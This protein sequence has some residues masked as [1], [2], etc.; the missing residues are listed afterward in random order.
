MRGVRI[1]VFGA[2]GHN[3]GDEAVAVAT[4]EE[5]SRRFP[6]AEFTLASRRPEMTARATGVAT[7]MGG[8]RGLVSAWREIR[9]STHLLI[10][11]GTLIQDELYRGTPWRGTMPSAVIAAE[12]ARRKGIPSASI[13]IG[14]ERLRMRLSRVLARRLA[15]NLDPLIVRDVTSAEELR[16]IGVSPASLHV[17]ADPAVLLAEEEPNG[18]VAG[19]LRGP[20]VAVSVLRENLRPATYRRAVVEACRAALAAGRRIVFIPMDDRPHD[21]LAE[22]DAIR[23]ALAAAGS[24][25]LAL[26]PRTSARQVAW[27]LRRAEVTLA[28]RLHAMI[29]S[30][31]RGTSVVGI[32]RGLKTET[33]LR[34]YSR[35]PVLSAQG[36]VE[37]RVLVAE[38]TSAFAET[39]EQRDR[40]A[41]EQLRMFEEDRASA[42]SAFDVLE[43]WL[44]NRASRA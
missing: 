42:R 11:G 12:M 8:R 3:I 25:V 16:A 15:S 7:F 1:C 17:A 20:Y 18:T 10:G 37:P 29:L 33:F 30:L 40:R 9:R 2:V 36:G 22:I 34:R 44:R 5:L 24:E 13:G 27:V 38:L 32:S 6:E 23:G 31:G 19:A 43:S 14:V 21:D 41:A 35:S 4:I 28:M 39:T 26:S